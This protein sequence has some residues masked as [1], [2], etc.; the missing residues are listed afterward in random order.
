MVVPL[1]VDPQSQ[2]RFLKQGLSVSAKYR[3]SS[4]VSMSMALRKAFAKRPN[5]NSL[6]WTSPMSSKTINRTDIGCIQQRSTTQKAI[7]AGEENHRAKWILKSQVS[8]RG[9]GQIP[10]AKSKS[11]AKP[12]DEYLHN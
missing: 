2:H 4:V 9:T 3:L 8:T 7:Q 6:E 1:L 12:L 11:W 10:L 5:P